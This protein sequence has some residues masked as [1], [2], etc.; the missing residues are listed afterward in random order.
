MTERAEELLDGS[1]FGPESPCFGCAPSH[2]IGFHLSFV[3]KGEAIET[4]FTPGT[5]YQG[6]PGIMHGGLVTAL[7]D[8]LAAWAIIGLKGQFGFTTSIEARLAGA[9]RVGLPLVGTARI[10]KDL[11]RIVEVET[12][13]AQGGADVYTA[14]FKFVVLDKAGAERLLG[15]PL[16]EA[17]ARFA[18]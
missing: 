10:T 17:W 8:E 13:L 16:P 9:V 3:K 2:P 1:I 7:A 11:R 18:R 5:Q 14:R 6:P 4:T 15:G 12:V